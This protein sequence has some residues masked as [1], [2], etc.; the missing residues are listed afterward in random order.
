MEKMAKDGDLSGV[1]EVNEEF[2]KDAE[3]LINDVKEWLTK[4]SLQ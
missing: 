3:T 1:L 4:N 2:I